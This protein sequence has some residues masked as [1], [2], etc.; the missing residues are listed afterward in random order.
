MKFILGLHVA[1]KCCLHSEL[2][3]VWQQDNE[4]IHQHWRK[5]VCESISLRLQ[6]FMDW[7][8]VCIDVPTAWQ[9]GKSDVKMCQ[10][11]S[12]ELKFIFSGCLTRDV[13]TV[14]CHLFSTDP[15]AYC[16]SALHGA[17]STSKHWNEI[18]LA[19]KHICEQSK[20]ITDVK[21]TCRCVVIL[22]DLDLSV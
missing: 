11:T 19:S 10:N 12:L 20:H 18:Q 2:A 22:R 9:R 16:E 14:A 5:C 21:T 7:W 6:I 15:S 1:L 4:E 17:M 8:R 13:Y 3:K